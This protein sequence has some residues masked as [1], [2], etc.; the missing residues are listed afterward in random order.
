MIFKKIKCALAV[1]LPYIIGVLLLFIAFQISFD[2]KLLNNAMVKI[3]FPAIVR[4][5]LLIFIP[6]MGLTLGMYLISTKNRQSEIQI[7]SFIYSI[8]ILTLNIYL[9]L[10]EGFTHCSCSS[11]QESILDV[12]DWSGAL[13][14]LL[15]FFLCFVF[16]LQKTPISGSDQVQP[17]RPLPATKARN[18]NIRRHKKAMA[19]RSK[20]ETKNKNMA[21]S[22]MCGARRIFMVIFR[23]IPT[24]PA[25]VFL[26]M[27]LFS[28]GV[29]GANKIVDNSSHT[30]KSANYSFINAQ[31]EVNKHCQEKK[32]EDALTDLKDAKQHSTTRDEKL[33]VFSQQYYVLMQLKNYKEAAAAMKEASSS[34][35]P[36]PPVK[37]QYLLNQISALYQLKNYPEALAVSDK[38]ISSKCPDKK[39]NAYDYKCQI[40]NSLKEYDKMFAAAV[41]LTKS[42]NSQNNNPMYIRSKNY[43]ITA[44][45]GKKEYDKAAKVFS[46]ADYAKMS[47]AEK[48]SYNMRLAGIYQEQKN[49]TAVA[50]VLERAY[51]LPELTDAERNQVLSSQ[52]YALYRAEKLPDCL[53]LCEKLIASGTPNK[54]EEAYN[55]KCQ[56]HAR[57]KE[58]DKLLDTATKLTMIAVPDSP[59]YHLAKRNQMTALTN[60]GDYTKALI[61]YTSSEVE[62]MSPE[63]KSD[64]YNS[65][66]GI[67]SAQKDYAA[68]AEAYEKAGDASNSPNAIA[69]NFNAAG[70]YALSDNKD[71]TLRIYAE[72]FNNPKAPSLQRVI[73][74]YKSAELL[75]R[76][77]KY[78]E[79][80]AI[81][82]KIDTVPNFSKLYWASAKALAGKILACQGRLNDAKLACDAAQHCF[83]SVI[84]S[85]DS[86]EADISLALNGWIECDI[87]SV[88]KPGIAITNISIK[89]G[90]FSLNTNLPGNEDLKI[91]Y[92]VP[93][94]SQGKPLPSANNIV[95]YAPYAGEVTPLRNTLLR[96]FSEKLGFTI[97][98]LNIK[99]DLNDIGERQKYYIFNESGWHDIVFIAQEE[100]IHDFNLNPGKLLVVGVSSGGSMAQLLGVHHP[101]K[102]DAVAMIGGHFFEPVDKNSKIV[103]LALNTWGCPN[104]PDAR[105]FEEQA[106]SQGI[107]VLRGETPFIMKSKDGT[108]SHHSPSLF[109]W[110]LMQAFIRDVA[111]LR[112]KNNGIIPPVDKWPVSDTANLEK[113]YLPSEEFA[114][115]WNQLPH[116]ATAMF[117]AETGSSQEHITVKPPSGQVRGIVLF[118][119]DPSFYESTHIMDNLYFLTKK[120]LI[121]VPVKM[122]DDYFMTLEKIKKTLD[123]IL[124]NDKWNNLP[125]YILGSGDGGMLVA[126]AAL[127]NGNARIKRITTFNSEYIWP[128]EKLSIATYRNKSQIPL[129]MLWDN[130]DSFVQPKNNN[131][132]SV[133]FKNKG[134]CFG[135]W[136]FYLLAKAAE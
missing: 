72:V 32:F 35:L 125:V 92:I 41:D 51:K 37:N 2:L 40:H 80:L 123:F 47:T 66:A 18:Q 59:T 73:S 75:D 135:K 88:D 129:R 57:L 121:T 74:I 60:K 81:I 50:T 94:D 7:L 10:S 111:E 120:D 104:T 117:E 55:L 101:D 44:L 89:E 97:F 91:S 71:D 106:L 24:K 126:V 22:I 54:R 68:A 52:A 93:V 1:S 133:L 28:F 134:T 3:N 85:P 86:S 65:I 98:S 124:K 79:A 12:K 105:Q 46:D 17:L 15:A 131:T 9:P 33:W 114:S 102:I 112:E 34:S 110:K 87:S 53:A 43:Q 113:Q 11:V 127:A 115:L 21:E 84:S 62:R 83:E 49:F 67:Y 26:V 48:L 8:L 96:Y 16:F 100:L 25:L 56:I 78:A 61:V 13:I 109:A 95:F 103:W 90:D 5:I 29:N 136:W 58:Y 6:G 118:V 19:D 70:M 107:Q 108:H 99:L 122:N 128:F 116:D 31:K 38:L 130:S 69:G 36:S 77:G 23:K 63:M 27:A 119:H 132:E 14:S 76:M 64:Y 30:R 82:N 20:F 42:T 45:L 39:E 4:L